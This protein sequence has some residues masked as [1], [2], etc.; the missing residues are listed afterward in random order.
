MSKRTGICGLMGLAPLPGAKTAEI[1]A[2]R[3]G[4]A[5]I[6]ASCGLARLGPPDDPLL[7]FAAPRV[8]AAAG[9]GG[10]FAACTGEI[11]PLDGGAGPRNGSAADTV[12]RLHAA[13]GDA[14]AAAAG[15]SFTALVLDHEP[16][17][18]TLHQD[19]TPGVE[20]L[21]WSTAGGV[22]RFADALPALA[23]WIGGGAR[24]IDPGALRE[25]LEYTYAG[26][27]RTF[28]SAIRRARA[29]ETVALDA[30]GL[31][32]AV[33]AP[34]RRV[35]GPAVDPEGA[36][37]AYRGHLETAIARADPDNRAVFLLSGGLDSSVNVAL[38]A[39]SEGPPPVTLA[40]AA[41]GYSD[42]AAAARAVADHVGSRH[43]E[44]AFTGDEIEDLPQLVRAFGEPF[45]EPGLLLTW[46]ALAE[47]SRHGE[48]V[49]GG[50]ATDQIFGSCAAAAARR[51]RRLASTRG[52]WRII[53]TALRS[54][55]DSP[56]LRRS[57]FWGR[58]ANR[59]AGPFDVNNWCGRYGFRECDLRGLLRDGSRGSPRYDRRRVPDRDPE[60]L[61]AYCCEVLNL[62][63]AFAGILAPYGP[64]ARML[65]VRP[66]SPYLEPEVMEFILGLPEDLRSPPLPGKPGR[67]AAKELHARLARDLLPAGLLA[68]PKQGGAVPL[69]IHLENE[70]RMSAV[71]ARLL[72]SEFL[73]ALCRRDAIEG[74][75]AAGPREATRICQLLTLDIWAQMQDRP[76]LADEP[77]LRLSDFLEL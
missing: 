35:P 56:P 21:F 66:R 16:R 19:R 42:D 36:L 3:E 61:R 73:A 9:P 13:H 58:V 59:I 52:S 47:A 2:A 63:Y 18:L 48:V 22:L 45:L 53:E 25:F 43:I 17:R 46:R 28:H 54:L 62:D 6:A 44:A 40:V 30:S 49:V 8:D 37:A 70:R 20:Q 38:A 24:N 41:P 34:W 60:A 76:A 23:G 55:A 51:S 71:R 5:R 75:C 69:R 29:G 33:A 72:R 14:L 4:A 77:D 11:R 7:L 12:L 39:R 57:P 32:S 50:E 31:R 10:I 26:A 74:L 65:G 27:P 1:S 67:F 64:L 15:G 68:R